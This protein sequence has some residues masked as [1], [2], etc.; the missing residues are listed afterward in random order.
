MDRHQD[1]V[2]DAGRG[3]GGDEVPI[4]LQVDLSRARPSWP[5]A[6]D[7]GDDRF[8]V[9]ERGLQGRRSAY[10]ARDQLDAF[11]N[12]GSRRITTEDPHTATASRKQPRQRPAEMTRSAGQQDHRP[13]ADLT[14]AS[15]P[16]PACSTGSR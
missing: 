15:T 8:D 3:R 9:D 10:I 12:C 4:A 1:E 16:A 13:R 7:G 2:F 6:G 14:A 5:E 11:W